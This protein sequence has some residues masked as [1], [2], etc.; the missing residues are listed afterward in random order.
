M[1]IALVGCVPVEYVLERVKDNR[2]L[3]VRNVPLDSIAVHRSFVQCKF[4]LVEYVEEE[5]DHHLSIEKL[6]SLVILV[7]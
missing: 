5:E 7:E 1:M 4:N 2:V 3:R 6:V